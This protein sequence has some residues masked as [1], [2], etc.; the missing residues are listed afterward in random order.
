MARPLR[1]EY[2]GAYYHIM[3]RGLSR[4][5]IF[6][7]DKGRG[8]F[9]DLLSDISR[10]WKIEIYAYCLMDNHYH[11]LVQTPKGGLSRA[12]RHLDGIY[13]Q[14]FNRSHHRDGPLFRGRYKAILIDA[15]EYFLSVVR[16][17]HQNP[18]MAGV[19]SDMDRY[20]WSSHRGYLYKSERPRWLNTRSV[21]S[22]FGRLREYR[23]FMRSEMEKGVVD[24]Y[25]GPYQRPILGDRG[26]VQWVRQRVG[27]R[28]RVEE[29]KPES[30]TVFGLGI[31]QIARVTA[32]VYGK[33]LEELRRSRRGEE[34]EARS[35]AMYLCRSLG[36][37]KHSEIGRVLGLEKTSS[38]SSAC[39]RMKARVGAERKIAR[40]A[41]RIEAELQKSQERT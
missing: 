21:L 28:A 29:E 2:P 33:R 23:E 20:R 30:R 31:E 4:R 14:R 26:F 15:E 11:L 1:I 3:N 34:N 13:T 35:M 27:E 6:L 37:H 41:Q 7:E 32:K 19:V 17:I 38:V 8:Q 9:L 36:G 39:L 18:V 10:L 22:R 5:E 12:M 40:R 25:R 16:Y 24:F